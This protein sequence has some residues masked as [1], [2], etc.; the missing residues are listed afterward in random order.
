MSDLRIT[1][2]ELLKK[3]KR[4]IKKHSMLAQKERVLIGLSGGPDSVCLLHVLHKLKD[5]FKLDLHALYIDHSLRPDEVPAE[6]RFCE[7]LCEN[8]TVPFI[9]KSIDVKSYAQSQ[10]MNRQEA[11]RALRYMVF[12]ETAYKINAHRIALGHTADDQAETLLMRLFRGSGPTGL[13]A[14]PPIRGIIIRPLIE[15]ERAEIERF[16]EGEK[17]DFIVDSSNLKKDYLRNKI[18]SSLIPMIKEYNPAIIDT[19]SRTAAIFREEN[20][21]LEIIVVRTMMRLVSRKTDSRI[22]FFLSPVEVMDKVILRR[23]LRKAI[24]ET[25]GLRGISFTHIEDIIELIKSGKAG[26]R[27]Y[28]PRG[29]R[30]IKK[31]S[32]F[33]LTSEP[34]V[35]LN[36]Y[37]FE[38]PGEVVLKEAGMSIKAYIVEK[39]AEH[40]I[41]E[42]GLWTAYGSFDADQLTFPLMVRPR[43]T[44]D[45]FCPFGF[46]RRKK[47]QDFFVD[48]KVPR[49]ERDK[50]PLIISGDDIIWVAGHR[51]DE[52]FRVKEETKRVLRLEVRKIGD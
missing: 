18:R 3:A 49:D 30:A 23:V 25:K 47:L 6:I 41:D 19:L 43:K 9:T 21:Y 15:I 5:D 20:K 44:G 2:M 36:T 1:S 8:L 38:V 11:A 28:L 31:Y 27:I 51:G 24:E 13:S 52:R 4:I 40:K 35:K 17:I 10:G 22:E 48:E 32:T 37:V 42:P 16:L 26:D 33:V 29:I 7:I 50:I 12:E 14:I 39:D 34:P 46:G 45:F